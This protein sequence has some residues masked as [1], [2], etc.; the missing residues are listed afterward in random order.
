VTGVALVD[1]VTGESVVGH[2][3]SRIRMR[4]Y[5]DDEAAAYVASGDA[6]DKAGAYAVQNEAFHPVEEVRGCYLNVVGLPVCTLLKLLEHFGV[7]PTVTLANVHLQEAGRCQECTKRL[8]R[9]GA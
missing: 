3:S 1:A 5:T 9:L 4:D 7:D 8:H 2:R 6:M